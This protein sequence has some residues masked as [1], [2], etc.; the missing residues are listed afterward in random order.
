VTRD[1]I[2][3]VELV[4]HPDLTSHFRICIPKANQIKNGEIRKKPIKDRFT[5]VINTTSIIHLHRNNKILAM[6]FTPPTMEDIT[7]LA[8]AAPTANILIMQLAAAP[9][10]KKRKTREKDDKTLLAETFHV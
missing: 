5:E 3:V 1:G 10:N 9:T 7:V 6:I 2:N 8:L 4:V